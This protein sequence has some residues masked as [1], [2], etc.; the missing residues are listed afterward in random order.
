MEGPLILPLKFQSLYLDG[1]V[2]SIQSKCK[3]KPKMINYKDQQAIRG[4]VRAI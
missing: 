3:R 4:I 1:N 2:P